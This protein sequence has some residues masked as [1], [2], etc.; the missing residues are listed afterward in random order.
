MTTSV[1]LGGNENYTHT[2]IHTH[3]LSEKESPV[4]PIRI[5]EPENK[6]CGKE[7]RRLSFPEEG[8]AHSVPG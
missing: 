4:E 7:V 8:N 2:H 6:P 1:L 5:T 3:Q